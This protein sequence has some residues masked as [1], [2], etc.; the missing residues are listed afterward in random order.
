MATSRKDDQDCDCARR[1]CKLR[2]V[3]IVDPLDVDT[4]DQTRTRSINTC[5]L[6]QIHRMRPPMRASSRSVPP[7][8]RADPHSPA[9]LTAR[10]SLT[11]DAT[12]EASIRL[13]SCGAQLQAT[14]SRQKRNPT[15]RRARPPQ[16]RVPHRTLT[17]HISLTTD[18]TEELSTPLGSC[19]AQLQIAKS[20][21]KRNPPVRRDATAPAA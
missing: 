18:A 16:R 1:G 2:K 19:G 6:P 10:I 5:A 13:G 9:P 11:I 15:V 14:K 17:D 21:R 7:A 3:K 4:A 12:E 20:H 8:S